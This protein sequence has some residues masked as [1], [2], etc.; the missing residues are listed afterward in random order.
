M[1]IAPKHWWTPG[2]ILFYQ[3]VYQGLGVNQHF[4]AAPKHWL[5]PF[6]SF[7]CFFLF[8]L[9][10]PF[11]TEKDVKMPQKND[12]DEQTVCKVPVRWSKYTTSH[13]WFVAIVS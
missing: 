2:K 4:R 8:V 7:M 1:L 6:F 3:E 13:K 5:A 10:F 9:F 11:V 12:F